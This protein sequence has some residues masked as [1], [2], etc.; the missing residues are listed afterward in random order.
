MPRKPKPKIETP[1]DNLTWLETMASS[2][3]VW[4][5][6]GVEFSRRLRE[7]CAE[8]RDLRAKAREKP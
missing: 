5:T 2:P 4:M 3:S 8:C 6:L 7:L 1:I